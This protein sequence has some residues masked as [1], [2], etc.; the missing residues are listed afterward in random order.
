MVEGQLV[1]G[2]GRSSQ[3]ALCGELFALDLSHPSGDDE[4][5]G[6]GVEGGAVLGEPVPAVGDL[7]LSCFSPSSCSFVGLLGLGDGLPG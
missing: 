7:P 5:V 3:L 1:R 6:A 2:V 4:R